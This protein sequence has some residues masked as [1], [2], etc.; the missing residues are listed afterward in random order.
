L[1]SLPAESAFLE[2]LL[3]SPGDRAASFPSLK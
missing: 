2:A 1:A 3:R